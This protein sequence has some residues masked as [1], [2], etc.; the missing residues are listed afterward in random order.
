MK[1]RGFTLIE[2]IV[3][4]AIIGI[5]SSVTVFSFQKQ[6]VRSREAKRI[7]DMGLIQTAIQSYV[8]AGK[9]LPEFGG[10]VNDIILASSA[11][12]MLVSD[13]Y[14]ATFPQ[15][16][17]PLTGVATCA[18]YIYRAPVT[19]TASGGYAGLNVIQSREY[20]ISFRSELATSEL[21]S[22]HQHP[23]N[24]SILVSDQT[25]Y[26]ACDFNEAFLFGPPKI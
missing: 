11:L 2:L 24:D 23:L 6:Q 7:G 16:S 18:S 9:E 21:G 5:L 4:I 19:A 14:L 22:N 25:K 13:G 12:N 17:K 8:A 15:E 10:T 20:A 26:A 3:V 1:Q